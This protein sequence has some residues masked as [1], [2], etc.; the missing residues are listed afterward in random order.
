M[1]PETT[2]LVGT[3][4]GVVIGSLIGFCGTWLTQ[5]Y[6]YRMKSAELASQSR[7]KAKE[8]LFAAYQER[9]SRI[10]QRAS[11]FGKGL[12][13]IAGLYQATDDEN[14]KQ[15][16]NA[17]LFTLVKESFELYREWFEELQGERRKVGLENTSPVQMAVIQKGLEVNL[18]AVNTLED[19]N[20]I[21]VNWAKMVA[22]SDSLWQ[23]VLCKKS[24]NL[25]NEEIDPRSP[26]RI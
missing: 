20:R 4:T 2:A 14:E 23:D 15:Q 10:S 17:A 3:L 21:V 18:Q 7:L 26:Q 25:F 22:V 5:R 6:Q 12:G 9:I 16:L 24:E 19:A 13:A 8:L 1:S 11:E